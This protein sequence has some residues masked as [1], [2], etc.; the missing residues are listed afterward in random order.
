MG[1]EH[2]Y[3]NY[4]QTLGFCLE[5]EVCPHLHEFADGYFS[6][7]SEEEGEEVDYDEILETDDAQTIEMKREKQRIQQELFGSCECCHGKIKKCKGDIC[8]QLGQGICY[9]AIDKLHSAL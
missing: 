6:D 8:R 7:D 1:Y 5:P 9:C 4:Y 2:D 3:C